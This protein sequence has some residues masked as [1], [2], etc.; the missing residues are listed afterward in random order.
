[1]LF[2][3]VVNN[4]ALIDIADSAAAA[5]LALA[6]A[7]VVGDDTVLVL[8][9]LLPVNDV[10]ETVLCW[11]ENVDIVDVGILVDAITVTTDCEYWLLLSVTDETLFISWLVLL[12]LEEFVVVVTS[13]AADVSLV[14]KLVLLVEIE[15][16]DWFVT[17][18]NNNK[19]S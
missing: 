14:V 16:F 1:M 12:V 15:L 3:R 5:M 19:S 10:C 11:L 4:D 17:P 9:L 7:F 13:V 6:C 8:L 18:N 2:A